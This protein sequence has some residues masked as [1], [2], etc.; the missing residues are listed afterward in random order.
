MSPISFRLL[1]TGLLTAAE[2]MAIDE[3]ILDEVSAGRSRPT[4]RFLRFSPPAVLVGRHQEV[5]REARLDFCADSGIDINR[6]I[7]GGGSIFFQSSALGWG[8]FGRLGQ[9]PF[10][11]AY[12]RILQEIC[13]AA[14]LALKDFGLDASYRPRND[15]EVNGR[16]IGGTGGSFTTRGCMFQGTLLVENQIELFLKSLRVPVEKLK[17]REIESLQQRVCFLEDLTDPVPGLEEIK[18]TMV[19]AFSRHLHIDPTPSGLTPA[20]LE[21]LQ[22]RLPFF[23]SDQWI[24]GRRPGKKKADAYIWASVQTPSGTLK[25]NLWINPRGNRLSQVLI[26]GDFFSRPSRLIMDLEAALKGLKAD[27]EIIAAEVRAFFQANEGQILG[28]DTRRIIDAF[29]SALDR[30]D[31]VDLGYRPQESNEL[32]MVNITPGDMDH[33]DPSWLLLPYCSKN[34]D[35]A[36][37]TI[38]DCGRCGECEFDRMYEFGL[39]RDL[40]IF[41]IQSFEHLME[42]LKEIHRGC[43][44]NS[45]NNHQ[46]FV[47]SCCEA[48]YT[49]H[50]QE[51]E[52]V[53]LP[54]VLINLDSTTCYDLGKGME[55]Y[56]GHFENKT[57]MNCDLIEK[58]I[59]K[60]K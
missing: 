48:F 37:R 42:V 28:I 9:P 24:S 8:L 7:T 21:A 10:D 23:Q 14:A 19:Q 27:R 11:G 58:V 53:G 39:N 15:I 50:Q 26:A 38:P 36:F 20:E 43:R 54:G 3:I 56:Y 5:E 46:Y 22:E 49:K 33:G 2:N 35:C 29:S 41:S 4:L 44:D 40:E 12:E 17:K 47:G 60:A 52:D 31:L 59:K 18:K 57:D 1:D 25:A 30:L 16:K 45:G 34:T 32:F 6:R 51:I 55:A 13:T